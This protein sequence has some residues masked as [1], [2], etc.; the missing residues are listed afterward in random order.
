MACIL[1]IHPLFRE[2]TLLYFMK[3]IAFVHWGNPYSST[4]AT[5]QEVNS[6]ARMV[7]LNL[8]PLCTPGD[9]G[10][11]LVLIWAVTTGDGGSAHIKWDEFRESAKHPASMRHL[12]TTKNYLVQMP[13]SARPGLRYS[14]FKVILW[15]AVSAPLQQYLGSCL[16]ALCMHNHITYLL[17]FMSIF[18]FS[19][20]NLYVLCFIFLLWF[21]NDSDLFLIWLA[22]SR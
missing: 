14:V 8:G 6:P 18:I 5:H 7:I 10:Q 16:K 12:H 9:I 4:D 22:L 1:H 17:V 2:S 3:E 21:I 20:L 15:R 13:R 11:C 19:R